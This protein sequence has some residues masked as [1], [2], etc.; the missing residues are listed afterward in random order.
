MLKENLANPVKRKTLK[1]GTTR[2]SARYGDEGE[3]SSKKPKKIV[4][5]KEN[6]MRPKTPEARKE[7]K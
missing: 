2:G 6:P 7:E 1:A 3:D 5:K 4:W